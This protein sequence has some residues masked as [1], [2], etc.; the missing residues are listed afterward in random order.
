MKIKK[1]KAKGLSPEAL[2]LLDAAGYFG[3]IE[4]DGEILTL[5][6]KAKRELRKRQIPSETLAKFETMRNEKMLPKNDNKSHP[7]VP[8]CMLTQEP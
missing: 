7:L 2:L 5:S 4:V 1:T 3:G 6:P 8:D